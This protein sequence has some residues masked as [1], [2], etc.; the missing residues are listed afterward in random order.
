MP[1][2]DQ[3]LSDEQL[4]KIHATLQRIGKEELPLSNADACILMATAE[5]LLRTVRYTKRNDG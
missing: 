5:Q 3:S 2:E 4:A 1:M